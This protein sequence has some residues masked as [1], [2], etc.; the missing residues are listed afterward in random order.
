MITK[1]ALL[2][3]LL[4][5]TV[6]L[7][8]S[9]AGFAM[10]AEDSWKK[11]T[12]AGGCFW[13]MEKPFEKIDGVKAVV[14]GY[15]GGE[16]ENPTY[17]EVSSGTTEHVE[18]VEIL[19]DPANVS[20]DYL[21]EVFWRQINPTDAGGQFVDRGK[22]YATAIFYHSEEQKKSAEASLE[23]LRKRKLFDDKIVTP[24][25]KAGVFYP[26]EDYHQ[27]YYKKNPLRYR[28]YRYGSGRDDYLTKIWK[29]KP[30]PSYQEFVKAKSSPR[31]QDAGTTESK[32]IP[33]SQTKFE[34]PTKAELRKRLTKMQFKV[35]QEDGTEPAFQNEY[36]DNKKAGIYVDIVSGEPLFSSKDKF[37]SG[38]GW[39]SFT[40]PLVEK[41]IIEKK[42]FSLFMSRI[43]VRSKQADSHLGHV[44]PDGP[45]PTGLRYCIN[46]A[47]L[48][49]IPVEAL[50]GSRYEEFLS[51]FKDEQ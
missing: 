36:W 6:A 5:L 25:R 19:Y 15:T 45:K 1:N 20:Y 28:Y 29:N 9:L 27:D 12:F 11:A 30:L 17:K 33:Q 32:R 39:P 4:T 34:K 37:R 13:C 16:E 8:T 42:D 14:S 49:F 46:S 40:R 47:A 50:A 35:T 31:K 7:A 41:N 38:T 21:L 3:A 26:A 22:Q 44:F 2:L 23:N 51:A 24:I 43:E 18:A 48:K 10:P